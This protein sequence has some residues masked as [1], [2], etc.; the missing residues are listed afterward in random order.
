MSYVLF[1]LTLTCTCS[2]CETQHDVDCLVR[3]MKM[4]LKIGKTAAVQEEIDTT[5]TGIEFDL[6]LDKKTDAELE[7]VV[8]SRV[9]TMCV[10]SSSPFPRP[11]FFPL[12]SRRLANWMYFV[13]ML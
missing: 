12:L 6:D 8:R 5:E 13:V 4:L 9:Q 11:L 3:G 2:Y 7:E 1:L 10:S